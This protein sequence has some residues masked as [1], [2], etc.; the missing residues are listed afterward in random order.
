MLQKTIGRSV[1]NEV[2]HFCRETLNVVGK[3]KDMIFEYRK[4]WNSKIERTFN[5]ERVTHQVK[6]RVEH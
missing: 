6:A 1:L 4:V 3:R 2:V 5:T